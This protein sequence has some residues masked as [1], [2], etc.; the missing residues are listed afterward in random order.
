MVHQS[1]R[2][3]GQ[4]L[5]QDVADGRALRAVLVG[6]HALVGEAQCLVSSAC[7]IGDQG[8]AERGG[9]VEAGAALGEGGCRRSR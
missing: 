6:V 2:A 9:D 4:Q 8:D 5:H 7:L 1:G 3:L